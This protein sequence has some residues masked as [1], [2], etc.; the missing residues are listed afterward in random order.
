MGA[1][2][3]YYSEENKINSRHDLPE[4]VIVLKEDELFELMEDYHNYRFVEQFNPNIGKEDD[5]TGDT[6]M[7][8]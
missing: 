1:K 4:G 2:E 3:Y 8:S 5:T 7:V 6:T